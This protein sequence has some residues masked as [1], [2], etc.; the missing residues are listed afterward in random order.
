MKKL[1]LGVITAAAAILAPST[2]NAIDLK[3]IL[4]KAGSTVGGVVGGLLTD[5]DIT[6]DQMVG[7]WTTTGSAVTFQSDNLLKKAGGSA[8]ST[9]IENK[10]NTYYQKLGLIGATLTVSSDGSFTLKAKKVSLK[11]TVKKRSDGDFDFTFT[12]FG[13]MKLGTIKAYVEKPVS[14]LKVMFDASKLISVVSTLAGVVN[15]STLNSVSS[16]L[17]SYDGLC[18]GFTFK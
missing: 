16:L 8:A 2:A 6:V 15:N 12:P 3:D 4:G 13:N 18:V 11:G 10:L 17:S 1:I 14:G 7:T 9:T 5:T